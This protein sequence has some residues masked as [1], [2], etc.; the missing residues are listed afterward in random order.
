MTTLTREPPL[1]KVRGAGARV[2]PGALT[3]TLT[4]CFSD[5]EGYASMTERLGDARTHQLLRAH[6]AMVRC[7]LLLHGG[8]EIKGEGDGFMLAFSTADDALRFATDLQRRL[9]TFTWPPDVSPIQVRLG[10]HRGELIRDGG[11]LFGRTV[12]IGARVASHAK[13]GE[14]LATEDVRRAVD[15]SFCFG[16]SRDLVL[17]GLKGVH[18]VHPLLG[19]RRREGQ[20]AAS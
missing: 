8:W 9:C 13:G 15:E 6:N 5:I 14:V 11:D 3:E 4:I 16:P 12:I 1:T 7:A 2:T 20:E 18:T 19:K 10:I 17:K